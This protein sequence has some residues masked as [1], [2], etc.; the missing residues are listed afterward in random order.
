LSFEPG[1]RISE[2]L[3]GS[4]DIGF[5]LASSGICYPLRLD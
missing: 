4:L 2:S 5:P 1:A 3:S